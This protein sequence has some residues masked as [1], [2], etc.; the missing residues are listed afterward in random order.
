MAVERVRLA[1]EVDGRASGYAT[2]SVMQHAAQQ[3]GD[4]RMLYVRSQHTR[5]DLSRS[6]L[7]PKL[8]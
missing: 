1:K 2:N 7:F 5:L 4:F 8:P 6:A 3:G